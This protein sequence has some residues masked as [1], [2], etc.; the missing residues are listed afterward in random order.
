MWQDV[1]VTMVA[2]GALGVLGR[3]WFGARRSEA[4]CPSCA[5]GTACARPKAAPAADVKP[6]VFVTSRGR[7]SRPL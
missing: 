6:V 4:A 2:M 5:S 1:L 3:R 7:S